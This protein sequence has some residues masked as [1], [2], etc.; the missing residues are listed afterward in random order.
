MKTSPL[1][2]SKQKESGIS[3]LSLVIL[4]AVIGCTAMYVL[5]PQYGKRRRTQI[6]DKAIRFSNLFSRL[7]DRYSRHLSNRAQGL[8]YKAKRTLQPVIQSTFQSK[9][10]RAD[11]SW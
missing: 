1:T 2:H 9:E 6:R 8:M 5:D 4:G 7:S 3:G 11:A 10:D